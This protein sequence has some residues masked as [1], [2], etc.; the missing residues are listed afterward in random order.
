M[1]QPTRLPPYVQEV[2]NISKLEDGYNL[3]ALA[4]S[5]RS[6]YAN[7][8]AGL[9]VQRYVVF[10]EESPLITATVTPW[11]P[12]YAGVNLDGLPYAIFNGNWTRYGGAAF[13]YSPPPPPPLPPPP[14]PPPPFAT[15]VE[16]G[17]SAAHYLRYYRSGFYELDKKYSIYYRHT[18]TQFFILIRRESTYTFAW[19]VYAYPI[20]K[21]DTLNLFYDGRFLKVNSNGLYTVYANTPGKAVQVEH[22][23]LTLG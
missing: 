17:Y 10:P 19:T 6:Y 20:N 1:T 22:I 11:W 21:E 14:L 23:R 9:E 12:S 13:F 18:D 16:F 15:P 4:T 3:Q 5:R 2:N 8:A 7:T